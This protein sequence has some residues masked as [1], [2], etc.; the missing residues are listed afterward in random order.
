M[1][2]NISVKLL[3][4]I[5]RG[6]EKMFGKILE[7]KTAVITGGTRGIGLATAK[8]FLDNGARVV[9][10]GTRQSTVEKAL[11]ELKAENE[12]YDVE[13]MWPNLLDY[14]VVDEVLNDIFERFNG[15]IDIFVN[16]A[17]LSSR[18]SLFDYKP[19]DFDHIIDVNVKAVF[20]C[21]KKVATL[22]KKQGCGGVIL[23]TSSMVS[24]YGQAVGCGYPTSKYAVNGLT[25][26]LARELGPYNIRVNGVAPGVIDTDM[27]GSLPDEMRKRV[28]LGIP[29]QRVGT[30]EDIANAFTFLASDL[31]SYISG[32]ILSVDGAL[33]K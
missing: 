33:I 23:N 31:A 8:S 25:K 2:Y 18:D 15:R 26:S 32:A 7:G 11:E 6:G 21:S 30:A 1:V 4:N 10:F 14:Y 19:S 12:D 17:G 13:G 22:M 16:N 20:N 5:R 27:F 9:I 29:L 3:G 24:F 28:S